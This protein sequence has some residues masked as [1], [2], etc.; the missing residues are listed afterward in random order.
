MR[1]RHSVPGLLPGYPVT[2]CSDS[3]RMS[4]A[5]MTMNHCPMVQ[6]M[7]MDS[8]ML[9]LLWP[10]ELLSSR[11]MSAPMELQLLCC[12]WHLPYTYKSPVQGYNHSIALYPGMAYRQYS[13]HYGISHIPLLSALLL[14]SPA[15]YN[16]L[17]ADLIQHSIHPLW[18][19]PILCCWNAAVP[20]IAEDRS[21]LQ[22]YPCPCCSHIH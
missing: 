22:V 7:A 11:R 17:P 21:L 5:G 2:S 16:N 6:R 20:A 4:I 14:A 8:R 19:L 12:I 1:S 15:Y 3:A 10:V 18:L 9:L 13:H